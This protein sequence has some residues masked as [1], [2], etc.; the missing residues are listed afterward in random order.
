MGLLDF[1]KKKAKWQKER[2]SVVKEKEKEA[3]EKVEE[4]KKEPRETV[5]KKKET[6]QKKK[7][8]NYQILHS[9]Y[10][11]E[12]AALLAEKNQYV[13]RV[14]PHA[15]KKEIKKAVEGMYGVNVVSVRVINLPSK[16]RMWRGRE[17]WKKGLRK[18]IVKIKEG[19]KI[20]I[21]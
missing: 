8:F 19:Q 10:L 13:F 3:K 9:P 21:L 15:N 11:S 12:K 17:G 6:K 16:R 18:A 14:Y 5:E 2:I 7:D 1:L 4:S 20:E